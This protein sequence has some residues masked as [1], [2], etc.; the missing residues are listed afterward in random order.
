MTQW[1][2]DTETTN[3]D[4]A[5][6]VTSNSQYFILQAWKSS[7]VVSNLSQGPNEMPLSPKKI[8]TQIKDKDFT[9]VT[10]FQPEEDDDLENIQIQH[11]ETINLDNYEL[12]NKVI[13][14]HYFQ[15]F[16]SYVSYSMTN[17]KNEKIERKF[18][19]FVLLRK[20][21]VHNFPGCYIPKIPEKRF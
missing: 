15:V 16:G 7:G 1:F 2:V 14:T 10:D 9:L 12:K 8:S 20:A 5:I 17:G 19:D 13:S 21:F 6:T 4:M 3:V 18:N 11:E